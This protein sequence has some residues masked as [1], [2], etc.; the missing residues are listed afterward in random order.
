MQ[1][2]ILLYHLQSVSRSLKKYLTEKMYIKSLFLNVTTTTS[3]NVDVLKTL[4]HK[5]YT[6]IIELDT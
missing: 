1:N 2:S 5:Q 6:N 4:K 3:N